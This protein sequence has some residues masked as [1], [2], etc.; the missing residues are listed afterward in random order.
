MAENVA[1]FRNACA[2]SSYISGAPAPTACNHF[3]RRSDKKTFIEIC[4]G[5]R[6]VTDRIQRI[7]YPT[8]QPVDILYGSDNDLSKRSNNRAIQ[9][10][11]G[12]SPAIFFA[13]P[14]RPFSKV[15]SEHPEQHPNAS[16]ERKAELAWLEPLLNATRMAVKRGA[17][18]MIENPESSSL[19]ETD[20]MKRFMRKT[21]GRLVRTDQCQFG[22][23]Y[24][25]PTIFLT[26]IGEENIRISGLARTC[27]HAR[28]SPHAQPLKGY[29]SETG[30]A[31]TTLA[32]SYSDELVFAIVNAF[33]GRHRVCKT[34]TCT[35]IP[36][37]NSKA[38][39]TIDETTL[40]S[41]GPTNK[42]TTSSYAP[43][44]TRAV[45]THSRSGEG[46][47]G[48]TA[49][50]DSGACNHA[51]GSD[52]TVL[53][54][55][56]TVV[57]LQPY[58]ESIPIE[59]PV[60]RAVG[61]TFSK[62]G[63]PLALLFNYVPLVSNSETLLDPVRLVDM[64]GTESLDLQLK[65]RSFGS[66]LVTDELGDKHTL[67]FCAK[68]GDLGINIQRITDD[69]IEV[70][71]RVIMSKDTP[72][73]KA[74]FFDKHRN[75]FNP[76][77]MIPARALKLFGRGAKHK[78]PD[79]AHFGW[80]REERLQHLRKHTTSMG[81]GAHTNVHRT[82]RFASFAYRY[83]PVQG[84]ASSDTVFSMDVATPKDKVQ[85]F[86]V[87]KMCQVTFYRKS[88]LLVVT[89]MQHKGQVPEHIKDHILEFGVPQTLMTDGAK[90]ANASEKI[91]KLARD[92]N[93]ALFTSEPF[94][95]NQNSVEGMI[96]YLKGWT[97]RVLATTDAPLYEWLN[98]MRYLA[99]LHN[100]LPHKKLGYMTP[101][102]KHFGTTPDVSNFERF[103]FYQ[104]VLFKAYS[105]GERWIPGHYLGPTDH[106]GNFHCGKVRT[107]KGGVTLSRSELMSVD[108][109][110]LKG[111]PEK[112]RVGAKPKRPGRDIDESSSDEDE[113]TN[114]SEVHELPSVP[115]LTRGIGTERHVEPDMT[116]LGWSHV[117]YTPSEI[118][119]NF[120]DVVTSKEPKKK[121]LRH[122]R[123]PATEAYKPSNQEKSERAEKVPESEFLRDDSDEEDMDDPPV[124][125]N[126]SILRQKK[127][128]DPLD[129]D[130][131]D[132]HYS[133]PLEA[134]LHPVD[135]HLEPITTSTRDEKIRE[136]LG[137]STERR[138]RQKVFCYQLS[139]TDGRKKQ[140]REVHRTLDQLSQRDARK[141]FEFLLE[142]YT[143][144]KETSTRCGKTL[145][146]RPKKQLSEL[147]PST[148]E[149]DFAAA[150]QHR[151]ANKRNQ[152]AKRSNPSRQVNVK[153]IREIQVEQGFRKKTQDGNPADQVN[154]VPGEGMRIN[155]DTFKDAKT[156]YGAILPT[157]M[158][159][160]AQLDALYDS[161]P[162]LSKAHDDQRWRDQITKAITEFDKY[163]TFETVP[164]NLTDYDLKC[165]GYQ[166]L[167]THWVYDIKQ[168]QSKFKIR[169]VA[170]GHRIK[171]RLD[172]IS[173][174]GV[175]NPTCSNILAVIAHANG[176]VTYA[177]D[178]TNAYLR[179]R[180]AEK[181]YI[182]YGPE[183]GP[184]REGKLAYV[185]KALYGLA[186]SA[187]MFNRFIYNVMCDLG[188]MQI[189]TDQNI[190]RRLVDANNA[191]NREPYYEYTSYYVDDYLVHSKRPDHV[192]SEFDN[193]FDSKHF[194]PAVTYLGAD[195]RRHLGLTWIS[196]GTYI[197]EQCK[198][199]ENT[200]IPS[201]VLRRARK[202][203]LSPDYKPEISDQPLCPPEQVLKYKRLIGVLQWIRNRGRF[204]IAHA[205]MTMSSYTDAPRRDH[206]EATQ[207]IFA[208]LYA[209]PDYG[210][211]IDSR[212]FMPSPIGR[213]Q[214][215]RDRKAMAEQYSG[216]E[217]MDRE[218]P[219]PIMKGPSLTAFVDAS[220]ADDVLLRRSTQ[221]FTIL[222]GSTPVCIKSSKIKGHTPSSSYASELIAARLCSEA[223]VA[224]R[225][226]IRSMGA[227]VREPTTLFMDNMSVSISTT[228]LGSACKKRHIEISYHAVRSMMASGVIRPMWID[229]SSNIAD[230]Q[231]KALDSTKFQLFRDMLMAVVPRSASR[232]EEPREKLVRA[233]TRALAHG[234]PTFDEL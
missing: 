58:G 170:G 87:P 165:M 151:A 80:A 30:I 114:S 198:Q 186:E 184:Q 96:G 17:K 180:A 111:A 92:L 224:I 109:A 206:M 220:H 168:E 4:A 130:P 197:R 131:L 140:R 234:E 8:H 174:C 2:D 173:Y 157:S 213:D 159:M 83:R 105:R 110:L 145:L 232:V 102:E 167:P 104:P 66:L 24:K 90:E 169:M 6:K 9:K 16:E 108:E 120:K 195:I 1:N 182:R 37:S 127:G 7:G 75:G 42:R 116:K 119:K 52:F 50:I 44:P 13:P 113:E 35:E 149:C 121:A 124:F 219:I 188:W 187:H 81:A 196:M 223:I 12:D 146:A 191:P 193:H 40:P 166:F 79:P 101:H 153:Q 194:G 161:N 211:P 230:A 200:A 97:H 143:Y 228:Q 38:T 99:K 60:G 65:K 100:V 29:D 139:I 27:N 147:T 72:W 210:Y 15:V 141:V 118:P 5:D 203:P 53:D 47:T 172:A 156:V 129:K 59:V 54:K 214:S 178:V 163:H 64:F 216:E 162:G 3:W 23:P 134:E 103:R 112:F 207:G 122:S 71:P 137:A 73:S 89:E 86:I 144:T 181:V 43:T 148:L 217:E 82:V 39:R 94:H 132:E 34:V 215:E 45:N 61:K 85:G 126:Q 171:K 231:T 179:A 158:E 63:D 225:N 57:S 98:C 26:N 201:N 69:E 31:R 56:S 136:I 150:H 117:E 106:I 135:S 55:S 128:E 76:A 208:Y 68:D 14:C 28:F 20:L 115:E 209:T 74:D 10:R 18:Y 160:A 36:P 19:W 155:L 84:E 190:W 22:R 185:R 62:K 138:G 154:R 218:A 48:S 221:G 205:V 93:M 222:M 176:L 77:T 233:A 229:T 125:D 202:T 226:I 51:I 175:V 95:Q 67:P 49:V 91:L 123:T 25:K 11:I 88:K 189:S 164:K 177:G 32:A 192:K 33:E 41:P 204:D 78:P 199:L 21:N 107:C 227:P 70:L 46:T 152:G 142:N 133:H 183:F 212:P